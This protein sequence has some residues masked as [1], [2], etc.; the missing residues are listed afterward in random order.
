M[1][2]SEVADERNYSVAAQNCHH[3][4]SGAYT[5]EVSS[6]M[7]HSLFI[8]YCIVG[9]SE[10]REYFFETN[11]M[12]AEKVDRCLD[13]FINPIFCCGEPLD[14]REAGTQNDYVSLQL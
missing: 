11:S 6:E 9:H 3:K 8:T 2:R 1:A 13:R 14:S 12:I 7:L 10:R 4:S 5:G